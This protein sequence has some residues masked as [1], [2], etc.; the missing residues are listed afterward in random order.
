MVIRVRS[1]M[2]QDDDCASLPECKPE[3]KKES[4]SFGK[5]RFQL[6]SSFRQRLKKRS[7]VG[8]SFD[9]E[10]SWASSSICS[11]RPLQ[12][13]MSDLTPA[14][15]FGEFKVYDR[16][17]RSV[18]FHPN[19]K[20]A[21]PMIRP[22]SSRSLMVSCDATSPSSPRTSK[23]LMVSTADFPSICEVTDPSEVGGSDASGSTVS[24]FVSTHNKH[25]PVAVCVVAM[26]VC[27]FSID[28]SETLSVV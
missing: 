19:T 2:S 27:A 17:P 20:P 23:S 25:I 21:A 14:S 18:R 9:E 8:S 1:R 15:R 28:W 10:E 26:A 5:R 13:S 11:A 22:R 4:S 16:P 24:T 7:S 6:G 12:R 3:C